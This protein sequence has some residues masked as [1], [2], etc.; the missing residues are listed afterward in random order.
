[1]L[2]LR[3]VSKRYGRGAI[4][5]DDVLKLR[6]EVFRDGV[7]DPVE[8]RDVFR[9]DH[10]CATKDPAWT[11]FYVDALTDFFVWQANPKGYV[12]QELGRFLIE[13]DYHA[14]LGHPNIP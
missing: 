4:G 1:M 12:D 11:Q 5:A 14:Y 6:R 10:A 2:E 13:F 8:A 9:L 3:G 7:V